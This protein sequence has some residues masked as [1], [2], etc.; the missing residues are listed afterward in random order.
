[1]LRLARIFSSVVLLLAFAA[2]AQ[3]SVPSGG[4][5][6][7]AEVV[8]IDQV[9][10]LNRLG[11]ALP[12]GMIFVLKSDVVPSDCYS[13]GHDCTAAPHAP[14]DLKAGQVIL[15]REKRPR[16]IVLRAN[17]GDTLTI[18]FWNLLNPDT[19]A[20]PGAGLLPATRTASMHL[21]GM[22]WAK[23]NTDDG[24]MAGANPSSLASPATGG[25]G[26]TPPT[27]YHLH[28]KGAGSFL[29]YSQAAPMGGFAGLVDGAQLASGLFGAVNI[30]PAGSRFYRSQVTKQDL[31]YAST[32][33]TSDGHPIINY[34]AKYPASAGDRA[35]T[36]VLNMLD[37][38]SHIV[39][40]D[41]T[42]I[43][44][45][46]FTPPPPP[47][48]AEPKR[49]SAYREFTII[50]HEA[51]DAVQAFPEFYGFNSNPTPK[52]VVD[53]P[54]PDWALA[55]V[56]NAGQDNFA[57]NYGTGAI[58][59]EV[60]ANRLG[61]GPEGGCPDCKFEEFFLSSWAVG[62]PA[63]VV[64]W[65]G[66][67]DS[68]CTT[69]QL[70]KATLKITTRPCIVDAGA[71]DAKQ[72]MQQKRKAKRALYPDD[73]SN[74]YHSYINDHVTFRILH[75]GS[76]NTHVHH[77]HAHQWLHTENSDE[78]TY[79]DSQMITMGSA[80]TLDIA[81]NGGGNRNKTV[82]D[83][84]FH[85]HFYPHFA[86]G[87]WSLWRT[88]D[89]FE[90]GTVIP[91]YGD[92]Q[93]EWNRALPDGEI[94]IGTPIP[95]LVPLPD[96]PMAPIP[97]RVKLVPVT[98]PST[99]PTLTVGYTTAVHPDDIKKGL[100]PG[101]PFFI[102]GIGGVRA[103]HP[104]LDFAVDT[105]AD[106]TKQTLDGGLPRHI[107]FSGAIENEV[108]NRWDFSKDLKNINA[109]RLPED[110]TSMEKV[111]MDYHSV[112]FHNSFFPNGTP[113]R[114][115]TNGLPPAPG[116]PYADPAIDPAFENANREDICTNNH[117]H[118]LPKSRIRQYRAAVFETDIV[119]NKIGWHYPQSRMLSLWE[120]VRPTLGSTLPASASGASPGQVPRP[121]QPFFFRAKSG[122][123]VEYW[124]TN[125][126]P[127]YYLLDDYQVRTPTDVIGQHIHLVKFDVTSSD[128]A[129]NGFNY[130]DGTFS[131]DE[132]R[133]RI[134][135]MNQ[136]GG[137]LKTAFDPAN[138]Y[139]NL[140]PCNGGAADRTTPAPVPPPA[141]IC[142]GTP[143]LGSPATP[144]PAAWLGAQTTVQRWF[145]DPL[146]NANGA[147]RTIRTVFTH[148]HMGPSTHQQTGL[149]A[150]LVIEPAASKW[151]DNETGVQ[152]G[153]GLRKDGGPTTWQAVIETPRKAGQT[154][155]N[156]YREFAIAL[157]DTQL[158]YTKDSP[159]TA[160]LQA[161][162]GGNPTWAGT[163]PSYAAGTAQPVINPA[164]PCAG[165][166]DPS[167]GP[168]P[169]LISS[170]GT[171]ASMSVNY[172]NE[173]LP[174]RV[175]RKNDPLPP[176]AAANPPLTPLPAPLPP[177]NDLSYVFA[178]IPRDKDVVSTQPT[179]ASPIG[180]SGFPYPPALTEGLTGYDPYTAVLRAYEGDNVQIR[181]IA[182]A[183]VL[184]HT[185]G[186]NGV[187][188]LF[189]PGTPVDP[190]AKNNSGW[191]N[192]QGIGISEHYEFL[193]RM[194][195]TPAGGSKDFTD[196]LYRADQNT[197]VPG[198][199]DGMWGLLRSYQSPQSN[200]KVLSTNQ[201]PKALPPA[202][203]KAGYSCPP[204][205]PIGPH[206]RITAVPA[207]Q[208]V[209]P[210]F[211][212][213]LNSRG[214]MPITTN[215]TIGSI[216]YPTGLL[217]V[218]TDDLDSNGILKPGVPIEPL[219]IRANAGQC[220]QID[221]T[222]GFDLTN[223]TTAKLFQLTKTL[224]PFTNVM[225]P[226]TYAGLNAQVMAY[227]ATTSNGQPVGY[228]TPQI[229]TPK[230]SSS[231]AST[232]TY[233]WYAGDLRWNKDGTLAK[234]TPI[235]LGGMNL[236]PSDPLFQN[237]Q[238]LVAALVVEPAHTTPCLDWWSTT[239]ASASSRASA[240][241]YQ[242]SVPCPALSATTPKPLFHE[243]VSIQQD[244]LQNS[245]STATNDAINYRTE[246]ILFRYGQPSS[247]Q[248][249]LFTNDIS[250][251]VSNGLINS[252]PQTPVFQVRAGQP[253]RMRMLH[254]GG[255]GNEQV[256]TLHG[257]AW[258]E[259]PFA[260]GPTGNSI[261][262]AS[263]ARS[264]WLGSRDE[265]GPNDRF[266]I[267][268]HAGGTFAV[269]GDYLFH[270]YPAADFQGGL[271]G[272]VRVCDVLP[273]KA[274]AV[275]SCPTGSA[276]PR[277]YTAPAAAAEVPRISEPAER[278]EQFRK[279]G[280]NEPLPSQ[281]PQP[282]S[283]PKP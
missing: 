165:G 218:N 245:Y 7:V 215:Q 58:G 51:N 44:R 15:R 13:G 207:S 280:Q 67:A 241:I 183:H 128:G 182:G 16:P 194:P 98:D 159:P 162:S 56:M 111:A 192:L 257:H 142:D 83:S 198:L 224:S 277:T 200:L 150:A 30:E 73:P 14:F 32:A 238:G 91:K 275:V 228:N 227:D 102:P 268:S 191:K 203:S 166:V 145:A 271:W 180:T 34:E 101:Y 170:G 256:M 81:Y 84:I 219:I 71:L 217:Y 140:P 158:A 237:T 77:Q 176:D 64:E 272:L 41:L 115:R 244:D 270:T 68:R 157:A 92:P 236:M 127:D 28:A 39:A 234:S 189:E 134:K 85:C 169:S 160:A 60:L 29:L 66:T 276:M 184:P 152:L 261:T 141:E 210:G 88:H 119:L 118:A 154:D 255:S 251:A 175:A 143:L 129:A 235:E 211:S 266:E 54:P 153:A 131:P 38:S 20:L 190:N 164:G 65:P 242:G 72:Y 109:M 113:G 155:A 50:Y 213:V 197:S 87:M 11:A 61:V 167:L 161:Y 8:A 209:R 24:S 226:S 216:T 10:L 202:A 193:F 281:L 156:T 247:N 12:Q 171:T 125:L 279:R 260:S 36:P 181:L 25:T 248:N 187:K 132:V 250:C 133:G 89:V 204:G 231:P 273:C 239:N 144:C 121:P 233:Y 82:G 63:E 254:P 95:A 99:T 151:Y 2:S 96:V 104:P 186:V 283:P 40:T 23:S 62:D 69:S 240:R 195:R 123:A 49:D 174:A 9:I 112:C 105:A 223:G 229:A 33:R 22:E 94:A 249:F 265:H 59:A 76:V 117:A 55:A 19:S 75:G 206:Y 214:P 137:L 232:V 139:A 246:P 21:M 149:Y 263:N 124:H 122:E 5:Q 267:V 47:N 201:T 120:D 130:E 135:D 6:L 269:T 74:V 37:P 136:C 188:W 230:T 57:I 46:P 3:T 26:S 4:R 264:N 205:A 79:L 148:D 262:I 27:I 172:R 221:L 53:N 107:I 70:T 196:Y 225:Y 146:L 43:I 106:G 114:F 212:I 18:R 103:P 147:D 168:C 110:G 31:D 86:A 282:P 93:P 116:A 138:P 80:Y 222:N 220:V 97:A 259:E 243:F 178:S 1:M 35:G 258:Q 179:P 45:A 52:Q 278:S 163:Q 274:P 173:P 42:A 177:A 17:V 208:A 126:V 90:G 199:S 252:D 185:F 108:H 48:Y 78:S 100:N 253:M